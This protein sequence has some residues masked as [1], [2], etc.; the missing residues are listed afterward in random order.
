M[1]R[2]RARASPSKCATP[3]E[4]AANGGTNLITV[5]AK[6]TSIVKS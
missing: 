6:P 3:V 1:G 2:L 4:S 5:P